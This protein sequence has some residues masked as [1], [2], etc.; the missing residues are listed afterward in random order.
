MQAIRVRSGLD[1]FGISLGGF[2]KAHFC[3][4]NLMKG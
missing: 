4:A 1:F 2:S 3:N